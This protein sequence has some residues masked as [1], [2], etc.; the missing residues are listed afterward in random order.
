MGLINIRSANREDAP[1]LVPLI[2][3]SSGGVWPAVWKA[4]ARENESAE[5]S[6]RRYLTDPVNDLSV[7]NT[8]LVESEGAPIG[9]MVSYQEDRVPLNESDTGDRSPLPVELTN[10]L[11]PYRELSDPDSLFI[12]E[13]CFLP[14]ARGKG[15]GTRL[16]EHAKESAIERGLPRV[17]LR[18]FSANVGAV[19]LYERFGYQVV[20]KRPVI[21]HPDIQVADF[22]YLMSYPV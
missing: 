1:F 17:T 20:G 10:A 3:E 13:I 4:L 2:A 9:A 11:R 22:V 6:G 12:A 21:P 18:V 7:K 8:I 15:L 14:A 19:R 5:A 16:L